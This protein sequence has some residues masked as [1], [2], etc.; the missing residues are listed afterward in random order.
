MRP[1]G[2]RAG[3]SAHL[4]RQGA[5]LQEYAGPGCAASVPHHVSREQSALVDA[6]G[7]KAPHRL[8]V[9]RPAPYVAESAR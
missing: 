4:A 2:F 7:T 8:D 5:R 6:S 1:Y 3:V 9:T